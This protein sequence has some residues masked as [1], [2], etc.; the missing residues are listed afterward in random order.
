MTDNA[1][2]AW[3]FGLATVTAAGSVLDVWFPAPQLGAQPEGVKAPAELIAAEGGD[4]LR[5]VRREVVTTEI[6]LDDAPSGTA[7]AYLRLHL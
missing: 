7:D 2:H 5:Q 3:G 4:D 6:V 1:T